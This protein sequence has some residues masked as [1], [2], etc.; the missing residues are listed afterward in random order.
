MS[1]Q[2]TQIGHTG[3]IEALNA[4]FLRDAFGRPLT[5]GTC[6]VDPD[7]QVGYVRFEHGNRRGPDSGYWDGWFTVAPTRD[8]H[9]LRGKLV[10][11]SMVS[12][13]GVAS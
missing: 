11:G 12:V 4:H 2:T 6:V 13:I 7:G 9:P 1:T 8:A 10:T 3:Q 5:D